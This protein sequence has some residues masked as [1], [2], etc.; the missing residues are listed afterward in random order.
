MGGGTGTGGD[1]AD[2]LM[3]PPTQ[4][5]DAPGE[6]PVG[7]SGLSNCRYATMTLEQPW[8]DEVTNVRVFPP[9]EVKHSWN[10]RSNGGGTTV[11]IFVKKVRGVGWRRSAV[12]AADFFPESG[13]VAWDDTN[14]EYA[15]HEVGT[16][17]VPKAVDPRLSS[18]AVVRPDPT[19]VIHDLPRNPARKRRSLRDWFLSK[20]RANDIPD[21]LRKDN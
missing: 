15:W 18:G 9:C 1:G 13:F 14:K 11:T 8:G 10:V 17:D 16:I 7:L 3:A 2:M 4:P 21:F 6:M 19:R 12:E 5:A 20:S